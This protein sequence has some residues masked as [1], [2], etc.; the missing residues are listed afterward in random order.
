MG[1]GAK[2]NSMT[3]LRLNL[4]LI[5]L[6]ATSGCFR[7]GFDAFGEESQGTAEGEDGSV[8]E[9]VALDEQTGADPVTEDNTCKVQLLTILSNTDD[10]EVNEKQEY[11][12]SGE[13][14]GEGDPK[15][16]YMGHWFSGP[17]WGF[18]RFQL[19]LAIPAMATITEA[20]LSLYGLAAPTASAAWNPGVHALLV[21][22]EDSA[23]APT[24][25]RAEIPAMIQ[26]SVR[27]PMSGGLAWTTDGDNTVDVGSLIR[28][29]VQAKGGLAAAAH[30]QLWL[31]GD[32]TV[33]FAELATPDSGA[34]SGVPGAVPARLAIRWCE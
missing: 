5:V 34:D 11:L 15:A 14:G 25:A 9:Q 8:S 4:T 31:R 30:V 6:M 17:C 13:A 7:G 20:T 23:D 3:G 29:L 12:P 10:G 16:I 26:P 18:Y 27:W 2:A 19:Q 22:G 32:F 33:V 24:V 21:L 28:W 1:K